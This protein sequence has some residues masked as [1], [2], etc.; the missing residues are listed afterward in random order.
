VRL[1]P[2]ASPALAGA[3]IALLLADAGR[4]RLSAAPADA[5]G[6]YVQRPDASFAWRQVEQRKVQDCLATRLELTSQTWRGHVWK[7][8]LLVVRPHEVRNP[9]IAFLEI[10]GDAAVDGTFKTLRNIATGAGALAVSINKIPNQ[11][12]YG[13]RR[14]DA[15]IAYTFDEYLKTGDKTWPL[16]FP[17][18]KSAVRGMDAAQAFAQREFG[19]KVERFVVSGASKRG[20]TT[21]LTAA[22]DPRVAGIVPMVIDVLNMDESMAHHRAVYEGVTQRIYG[23]YSDAVRDYVE[24]G[25]MD[26]LTTP[27]GIDLG[28]IVDPFEYRERFAMPKLLVNST[29]DQF[30]VP[31]SARFYFDGL[32]GPKYLRYIPNTDH[33][34]NGGAAASALAFYRALLDGGA[35]PRFAWTVAPD[36]SIR[37]ET[38]DAP[39]GAKLWQATNPASRDFRLDT[40]GAIWTGAD[41]AS[42]GGGAWTGRVA[43]P[44]AGWTAFF[45]ELRYASGTASP[46]VFTTRVVAIGAGGGRIPGDINGDGAID[47]SDAVRLLI[48]LFF[49][50]PEPLP[51]GAG[52]AEPGNVRL[53]DA[54]GSG[55]VE[56]GDAVHI[57]SHVFLAGP[58]PSGGSA[59]TRM[60]GC[61][62]TCV[63]P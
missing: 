21:W 18:V 8:Q 34:L 7:H 28:R 29:G 33:G 54:N 59:C 49:R 42:D 3:V 4:A 14:E 62:E 5:L 43:P 44:P 31:D 52:L 16:L 53:A 6:D 10:G 25:I 46:H 39:L 13:D 38:A 23:G 19:Q 40:P 63:A 51:C 50:P 55:G 17:M 47:L 2:V 61:P 56:V 32:P 30:F 24:L 11:P 35:L 57:L 26:R 58:P 37:V 15:L 1:F 12:L 9:D 45:V 41:L 20:W 27:G 22:V 60:E 36:G 48:S